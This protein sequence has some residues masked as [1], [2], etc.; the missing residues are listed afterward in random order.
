MATQRNQVEG[1]PPTK[2]MTLTAAASAPSNQMLLRQKRSYPAAMVE[3][4]YL[5]LMTN[6][7]AP[8]TI[9][10]ILTQL[11]MTVVSFSVIEKRNGPICP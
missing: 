3:S 4:G 2:L 9:T 7:A 6:S 5:R 1:A 8:T 10:A 11:G